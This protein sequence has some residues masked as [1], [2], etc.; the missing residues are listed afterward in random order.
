MRCPSGAKLISGLYLELPTTE[1]FDHSHAKITT[2][3][4]HFCG[5][6][7]GFFLSARA[8]TDA[9]YC[10]TMSHWQ[11]DTEDRTTITAAPGTSH[12][13]PLNCIRAFQ[14]EDTSPETPISPPSDNMGAYKVLLLWS[15]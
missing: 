11:A 13:V 1:L 10:R 2:N 15:H 7:L 6:V 3:L 9:R 4:N 8:R 5:D 14:H 12:V